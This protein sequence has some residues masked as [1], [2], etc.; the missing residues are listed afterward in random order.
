MKNTQEKWFH[1]GVDFAIYNGYVAGVE[2]N[3]F[4]PDRAVARAMVTQILYA[5]ERKPAVNK[6]A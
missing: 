1:N 3:L 5:T 4:A 2:N 6:S